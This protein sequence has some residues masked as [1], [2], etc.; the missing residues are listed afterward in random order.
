MTT[1]P[2]GVNLITIPEE[3]VPPAYINGKPYCIVDG[4]YVPYWAGQ[5]IFLERKIKK[6]EEQLD[7]YRHYAEKEAPEYTNE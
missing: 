6:L 3:T 2:D 4:E 1:A 7:L 5:S